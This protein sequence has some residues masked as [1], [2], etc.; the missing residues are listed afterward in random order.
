MNIETTG[1]RVK[2][3]R[4]RREW[5]QQQLADRA[6]VAQSTINGIEKGVRQKMPSSLI[7]IADALNVDAYWLKTG[8]GRD[9]RRDA[10]SL[11]VVGDL[12]IPHLAVRAS[13]GIGE[14]M[15]GSEEVIER[16][17]LRAE[18]LN[19]NLPGCR[20][21][22]LA[23]ISG[24]GNSMSPTFNDGD[25]LLVDCGIQQVDIDGVYVLSAH[26]RLFIKTVR[27]RIDGSFEISSDN[28]SVK[29]V[30]ILNGEHQ[31]EIH[32]RVV[33]AWNGKRM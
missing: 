4:E 22:D 9:E 11:T 20:I 33:W 12:S 14:L 25:L 21:P 30:D 27:Q 8:R 16:I 19:S 24:R 6:G 10:N 2:R 32:G 17:T 29:T 13:M 31:V 15:E 26:G 7:E 23:V 3:L 28:P 1:D 18:W 5:T